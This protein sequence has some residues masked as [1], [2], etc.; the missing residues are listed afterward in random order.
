MYEPDR[1]RPDPEMTEGPGRV[2][3]PCQHCDVQ[4]ARMQYDPY[5]WVHVDDE[6][7]LVAGHI[8][9]TSNYDHEPEPDVIDVEI[10]S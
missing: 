3:V 6:L 8:A 4:L 2:L 9:R 10:I 7:V 5:L 1:H